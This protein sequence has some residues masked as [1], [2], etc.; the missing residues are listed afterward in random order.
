MNLD[1]DLSVHTDDATLEEEPQSMSLSSTAAG[2]TPIHA[3]Y[4]GREL[5]VGVCVVERHM[6]TI[7]F[8]R[9]CEYTGDAGLFAGSSKVSVKVE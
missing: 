9:M 5:L 2:M 4:P 3:A 1:T 7:G 6:A 8:L